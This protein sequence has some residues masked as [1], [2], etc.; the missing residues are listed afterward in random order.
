MMHLMIGKLPLLGYRDGSL[1][2][3]HRA[4]DTFALLAERLAGARTVTHRETSDRPALHAFE[5]D[6]G[7]HG[8]LLVLWDHRDALDGEDEP[9]V[10]ITWPW[11]AVTVT[12]TDVFGQTQTVQSQDGQIRGPVSVTPVFVT[13]QSP[14]AGSVP[15]AQG[16]SQGTAQGTARR[17]E[18][19]S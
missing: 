14:A 5:V 13:E 19:S 16:A 2:S 6:R 10:T 15:P 12:V 9:P 3:R 17:T 8:P 11:P 7:E 1:G 18:A 4:A